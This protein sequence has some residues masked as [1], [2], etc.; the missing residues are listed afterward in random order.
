M[1]DILDEN[2]LILSTRQELVED[3]SDDL[4]AI[5]G[6]DINLDQNSPD[7]QFVNI[8]TQAGADVREFVYFIYNSFSPLYASGNDLD[9]R[10]ALNGIKRKGGTYTIVDIT[11]VVDRTL[12]LKGLDEK[13]ND[14]DGTGYTVQDNAGNQ[15][16]LLASTTLTKGV[17]SLRF[18]AKEIGE[19]S[20]IVNTITT[21]SEIVLGVVSVNNQSAPTQVGENQ[22]SDVDLRARRERSFALAALGA[23]GA[24]E[25]SLLALQGVTE[26]RVYENDEKFTDTDGIPPNSSWV[27]VDGGAP[28][29]IAEILD[30]KKTIGAGWKGQQVV[31]IEKSNNTL[32]QIKFDRPVAKD[33]YLKFDIKPV[34]NALIDLDALKAY[35]INNLVYK[36]GSPAESSGL[37]SLILNGINETAGAGAGYPL[38]LL[39]SKDNVNYTEYLEVDTK[40]EQYTLDVTRITITLI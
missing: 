4:K 38:D 32:T 23:I 6:Q 33:L 15:F 16:I 37:V 8:F 7:G 19:V 20:T 25:A 13:A 10:V 40:D 34:N 29:D 39:V 9:Q 12:S 35:I 2:G 27:I 18:R 3:T 31:N 24:M 1:T 17:H 5:Y 28:N 14:I 22:E 36:I 30:R 26:A 11:I 21:A